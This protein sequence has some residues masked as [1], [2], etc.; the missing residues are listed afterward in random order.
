MLPVARFDVLA[1]GAVNERGV[2]R[3]KTMKTVGLLVHVCIILGN[4]LPSHL[5]WVDVGLL[6]RLLL[7]RLRSGSS[8]SGHY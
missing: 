7:L 8:G 2:F 1:L 6:L 3:V 5:G 4:E